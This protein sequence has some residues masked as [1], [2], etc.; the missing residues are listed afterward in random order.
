MAEEGI[1]VYPEL[2]EAIE[3]ETSRLLMFPAS[4]EIF[5]PGGQ[6]P[7]VGQLLKQKDLAGKTL[8][9]IALKGESGF[10]S[11]SVAEKLRN[12]QK[13]SDGDYVG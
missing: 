10:Y 9:S 11:G 7:K 1:T 8:R 2:A 6:G 13:N 3:E 4:K 12:I 5:L